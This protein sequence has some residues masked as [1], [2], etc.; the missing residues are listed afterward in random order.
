MRLKRKVAGKT[1]REY[2][3]EFQGNQ[4]MTDRELAF[5]QYY[6]KFW[7]DLCR[8]NHYSYDTYLKIFYEWL[9]QKHYGGY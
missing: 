6:N 1:N 2:L 9:D 5:D 7:F 4:N 8:E 3:K